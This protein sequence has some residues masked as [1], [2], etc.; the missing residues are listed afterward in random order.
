MSENAARSKE[1]IKEIFSYVTL[2]AGAMIAAFAIEEFLVPCT[3]L[4]GGVVGISIMIN[5]LSKIPLGL[6]TLGLNLP[7]LIVGMRKLGKIFIAKSAVAMV[8]FSGFLEIFASFTNMT[9]DYLLA[10][11]FGGVFLGIG[12]GLVIRSGGCLDGT[13]TVAIVMNRRFNLPVGQTVLFI[14]IMIYALAGCLFGFDRAMYSLLT[15][16]ITS[17]VIDFVETGV[18]QAKA[19]MIITNEGR[20][21][22]DEIYKKMGRTVT[23][24]EG[25][26]LISGKKVIL[27]CVLNRL[28]IYQ[29]KHLIQE[30]DASAFIT[31][32][33]VSEIIGDHIKKKA[34]KDTQ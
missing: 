21:I 1:Y 27:Y 7:F 10:V 30:V 34:N 8:T 24:L 20:R 26:G 17:K 25:E 5:N 18:E 11:C 31:I 13:E 12:V 19:A 16:F 9:Q 15:Y 6:L 29:L 2:M 32:S 23:I 3:I 4:D 14:N 33:D 28:E 22:A